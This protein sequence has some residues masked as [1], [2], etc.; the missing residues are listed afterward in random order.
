MCDVAWCNEF[1]GL[2]PMQRMR[3]DLI[4]RHAEDHG[5]VVERYL[6]EVYP[7]YWQKVEWRDTFDKISK[8]L[9]LTRADE[10]RILADVARA[11][12]PA[13]RASFPDSPTSPRLPA[14]VGHL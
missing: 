6:R 3:R 12:V 14:T 7:R 10:A 13:L 11:V 9:R 2:K 1:L 4:V 8:D 5:G